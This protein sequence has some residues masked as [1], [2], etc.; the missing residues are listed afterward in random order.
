M[1]AWCGPSALYL[2]TNA[3]F[4]YRVT[5]LVGGGGGGGGGSPEGPR[6]PRLI[7]ASRHHAYGILE[8]LEAFG[9]KE[10]DD[11]VVVA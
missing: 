11:D 2:G 3:G 4:V 10:A 6:M 1:V 7:L 9:L 8:A 5:F